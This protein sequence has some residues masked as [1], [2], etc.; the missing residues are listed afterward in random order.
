MSRTLGFSLR[1]QGLSLFCQN[2]LLPKQ[3]LVCLH[4]RSVS[5]VDEQIELPGMQMRHSCLLNVAKS[6][7][8]GVRNFI[9]MV[10]WRS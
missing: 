8:Y 2:S 7:F 5:L 6:F 1:P 3:I 9:N 4:D 10:M